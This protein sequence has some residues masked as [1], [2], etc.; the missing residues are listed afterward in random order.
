VGEFA[1][2]LLLSVDIFVV[3]LRVVCAGQQEILD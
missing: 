3:L 2:V 1:L